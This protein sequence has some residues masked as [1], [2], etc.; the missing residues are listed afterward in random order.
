MIKK[1]PVCGLQPAN[2]PFF[3]FHPP[4]AAVGGWEGPKVCR[5]A[6]AVRNEG[7]GN[8][9]LAQTEY[10]IQDESCNTPYWCGPGPLGCVWWHTVHSVIVPA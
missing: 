2:R 5:C 6:A 7:V 1:R 8:N 4:P 10:K 3:E 9:E